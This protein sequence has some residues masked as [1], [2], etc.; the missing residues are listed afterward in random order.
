MKFAICI[1]FCF[2]FQNSYAQ[3][4]VRVLRQYENEKP[5]TFLDTFYN[6]IPNTIFIWLNEGFEDSLY[7]TVNDTIVLNQSLKSN[8]SIGYAG[9]VGIHFDNPCE[10][11]ILRL[12]FIKA[13]FYIEE[14]LNLAYKSLEIRGLRPWLLVYTNHFYMRE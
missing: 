9:G 13:N 5:T 6:K 12:K 8:E 14:K 11:K 7:V 2:V 1:L 10:V 4:S 3:D